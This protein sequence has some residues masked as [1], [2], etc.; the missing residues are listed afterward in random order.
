MNCVVIDDNPADRDLLCNRIKQ[1]P[2]VSLTASF[3]LG[4]P[5]LEFLQR[6]KQVN[7]IFL[8]IE[9]PDISGLYF[10]DLLPEGHAHL[11]VFTSA[12]TSSAI[13]GINQHAQVIGFLEKIYSYQAFFQVIQK[14]H[15]LLLPKNN[16][17]NF[18]DQPFVDRDLVFIKTSFNRKERYE[19]INLNDLIFIRSDRNYVHLV[20]YDKEYMV[21]RSMSEM[22]QQLS[23]KSFIR[24]HKSFLINLQRIRRVEVKQ[25]LMDNGK[26]APISETYRSTIFQKL[27]EMSIED[28]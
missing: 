11:I 4:L 22:E 16:I 26:T 23:K 8:D 6:N 24:V 10:L 9:M 21:K 7:L 13:L 25:L 14:A 20:T 12:H 15:R 1:T 27:G 18:H 5:A 19:R 17:E 28:K 2:N 3:D